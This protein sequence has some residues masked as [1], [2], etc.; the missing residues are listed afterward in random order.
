MRFILGILGAFGLTALGL[1]AETAALH[2]SPR[3]QIAGVQFGL[4][5]RDSGATDVSGSPGDLITMRVAAH[6]AE[7]MAG[8]QFDIVFD[9][10]VV[11]VE[12]VVVLGAGS[13][14]LS[15]VNAAEDGLLRVAYAGT[16][17]SG[18]DV[19]EI[20]DVTFKLVGRPGDATTLSIDNIVVADA[21][22]KA[23]RH[24][25]LISSVTVDGVAEDATPLP[26]PS[27]PVGEAPD[28]SL[29]TETSSADD[30]GKSSGS[31]VLLAIV[32]ATVVLAAGAAMGVRRLRSTH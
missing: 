4:T 25:A 12:D 21:S 3:L 8:T 23:L 5:D 15:D 22:L 14:I 17:A 31:D 6:G 32:G 2:A 7:E 28:S 9:P 27:G 11:L 20:A 30:T 24:S 10:S 13:G 19:V 29:P 16:V 1:V 18:L 26:S